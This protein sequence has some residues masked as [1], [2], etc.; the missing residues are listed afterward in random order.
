M[1]GKPTTQRLLPV[2][3]PCQQKLSPRGCWESLSPMGDRSAP[4]GPECIPHFSRA[5]PFTIS[6]WAEMPTKR[7]AS[8]G[9][10][11]PRKNSLPFFGHGRICDPAVRPK[12]ST[13][14]GTRTRS[15]FQSQEV[16]HEPPVPHSAGGSQGYHHVLTIRDVQAP[17]RASSIARQDLGRTLERS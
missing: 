9:K 10:N 7:A 1:A 8:H 11:Y 6:R 13:H 16:E 15:D 14:Y 3:P 17:H 12:P 2:V 5:E 4:L